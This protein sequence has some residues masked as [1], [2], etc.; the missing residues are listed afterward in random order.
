MSDEG[1]NFKWNE[2]SL[3]VTL[4]QNLEFQYLID[5]LQEK[6]EQAESF[7]INSR[8]RIELENRNITAEQRKEL[9]DIFASLPGLSVIE[10]TNSK[11]MEQEQQVESDS[12]LP[13][14]LLDRTLRSGQ[15]ITYEGNIVIKGDVNPGAKVTAYGDILVLGSFR[16]VGHAGVDGNQEATIAAFSLRPI[17]LRI[18]N[19]LCRSPDDEVGY[20]NDY[21]DRPEIALIKDDTILIKKLKN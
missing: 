8:I 19:K 13:T 6:V 1:I 11:L 12:Q 18:A 5:S 14:L 9:V 7:F 16:G 15:S 3:V 2:G 17:Q 21:S 20:S 4:D 10:I